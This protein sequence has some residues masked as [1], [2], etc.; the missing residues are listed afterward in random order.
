MFGDDE[1]NHIEIRDDDVHCR[2]DLRNIDVP[3][4]TRIVEIARS[5][6]PPR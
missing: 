5:T 3:L 4:L 6:P 2:L 1:S